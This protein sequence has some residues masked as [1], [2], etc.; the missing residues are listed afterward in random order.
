MRI[1]S[2][3]RPPRTRSCTGGSR[4]STVMA[5]PRRA[6]A[7]PYGRSHRSASRS[8]TRRPTAPTAR[9]FRRGGPE[10]R[11]PGPS[12]PGHPPPHVQRHP[13]RRCRVPVYEEVGERRTRPR[14]ADEGGGSATPQARR[15]KL[16]AAVRCE[17]M[18]LRGREEIEVSSEEPHALV[19]GVV[20]RDRASRK[21]RGTSGRFGPH[22]RYG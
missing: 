21:T 4:R 13:R 18:S 12:W 5:S 8:R 22:E 17:L 7:A 6:N 19:S 11:Q 14:G 9:H 10:T 1:S 3:A 2:R 15:S 20:P 16:P